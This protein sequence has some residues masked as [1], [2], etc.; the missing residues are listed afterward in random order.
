[1][2]WD[3]WPDVKGENG[4]APEARRADWIRVLGNVAC[5]SSHT[6]PTS[7]LSSSST[8]T[9][10]SLIQSILGR[11]SQTYHFPSSKDYHSTKN[12]LLRAAGEAPSASESRPQ[13]YFTAADSESGYYSSAS[14]ASRY[15]EARSHSEASS[16]RSSRLSGEPEVS[17]LLCA[18]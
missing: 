13:S 16:R 8:M 12:D 18:R 6:P 17:S 4:Q 14:S 11:P 7:L 9:K 3:S 10:P 15:S 2:P 1:M 5:S